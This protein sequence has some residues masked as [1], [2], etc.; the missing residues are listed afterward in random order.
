VISEASL[1]P[2][3]TWGTK[4]FWTKNAV[5]FAGAR[6]VV[7]SN[8]TYKSATGKPGRLVVG[9]SCENL[10]ISDNKGFQQLKE[11]VIPVK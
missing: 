8:N 10:K 6:D 4:L 2:G 11:N 5:T 1:R 3:Q 9:E 7:F